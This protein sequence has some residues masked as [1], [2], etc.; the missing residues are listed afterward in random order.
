MSGCLT[1]WL[2]R[3][4]VHVDVITKDHRNPGFHQMQHH[5]RFDIAQSNYFFLSFFIF[6]DNFDMNDDINEY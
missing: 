2:N 1:S 4:R 3:C 6:N 5:K